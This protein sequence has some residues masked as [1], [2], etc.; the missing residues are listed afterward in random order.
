MCHAEHRRGVM[1]P[2]RHVVI[3]QPVMATKSFCLARR[4]V[5]G[6]RLIG[7]KARKCGEGSLTKK[8][9]VGPQKLG[10]RRRDALNL[11]PD[12]ASETLEQLEVRDGVALLVS[13]VCR[14]KVPR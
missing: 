9:F 6:L 3:V 1:L 12:G 10:G 14:Q 11:G 13:Q 4:D 8:L 2:E 7:D 5:A